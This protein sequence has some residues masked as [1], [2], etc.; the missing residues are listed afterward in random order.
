VF[1]QVLAGVAL[2]RGAGESGMDGFLFWKGVA[3]TAPFF[4]AAFLGYAI[5]RRGYVDER[6]ILRRTALYGGMG[7]VLVT[8]F[9]AVEITLS[10]YLVDLVP[11]PGQATNLVAALSVGA[12]MR[13]LHGRLGTALDGA[14]KDGRPVVDEEDHAPV[15]LLFIGIGDADEL[16]Q[17]DAGVVDETEL[18]FESALRR[19]ANA[20]GGRI[21]DAPWPG[22]RLAFADVD[23][24]LVAARSASRLFTRTTSGMGLPSPTPAAAIDAGPIRM[25]AGGLTGPPVEV[26][27]RLL[28]LARPGEI[29]VTERTGA[30]ADDADGR[31]GALSGLEEGPIPW[32]CV[33]VAEP[34]GTPAGE[35]EPID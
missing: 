15:A 35:P 31:S 26:V 14:L 7:I 30:Q 32:R 25:A 19:S 5:L 1:G 21:L 17:A 22:M 20:G 29:V 2:M 18:V 6:L 12:L 28:R 3:D 23:A 8:L 9:Q 4:L 33:A 11:L 16:A 10:Q 13:P 27:E 24:A 34:Q